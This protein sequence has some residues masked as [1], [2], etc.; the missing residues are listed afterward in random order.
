MVRAPVEAEIRSTSAAYDFLGEP[1]RR[2]S[3]F[4]I[5]YSLAIASVLCLLTVNVVFAES[6]NVLSSDELID[7]LDLRQPRTRG[8]V[9]TT[10]AA[11]TG[12]SAATPSVMLNIVF[13][14]NSSELSQ[15]SISQ[16]NELGKALNSET[17]GIY[18]FDVAGHTDAAGSADFN[19]NLSIRR[20]EAVKRYLTLQFRIRPERLSTSG[21]GE[22]R[23]IRPESPNHADNRRVEIINLGSGV[24]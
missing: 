12:H 16:L 13:A 4:V 1:Y 6:G 18:S 3:F 23:L 9:K 14:Y 8:L 20:A 11:V 19:R 7:Q 21:W 15:D 24:Q 10:G 5:R 2:K 22:D 17:L